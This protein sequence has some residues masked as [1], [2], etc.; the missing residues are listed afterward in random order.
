[1]FHIITNA[2]FS[3]NSNLVT[4]GASVCNRDNEKNEI[5]NVSFETEVTPDL[6]LK[7][8]FENE[9]KKCFHYQEPYE[10]KYLQ[11]AEVRFTVA[12]TQ[13]RQKLIDKE[14]LEL[15]LEELQKERE[16]AL[17]DFNQIH[18]GANDVEDP[19]DLDEEDRDALDDDERADLE[20]L[21]ELIF[22]IDTQIDSIS[23]RL[24]EPE[25]I[26]IGNEQLSKF[27]IESETI[28]DNILTTVP[29]GVLITYFQAFLKASDLVS[30]YR[31]KEFSVPLTLTFGGYG[32]DGSSIDMELTNECFNVL[33]QYVYE[34]YKAIP[35]DEIKE[36]R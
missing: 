8:F 21:E 11:K 20:V 14:D 31:F 35:G 36:T 24:N 9:L 18:N 12:D 33:K 25:E 15:E 13:I 7:E 27:S 34:L 23:K 19:D 28:V 29:A 2:W 26:K 6:V 3:I 1:M 4:I 22:D 32:S 10:I 5:K 30:D 17:F 16:D